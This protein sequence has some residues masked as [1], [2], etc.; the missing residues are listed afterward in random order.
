MV[1]TKAKW[2][3]DQGGCE[4]LK[5]D[6]TANHTRAPIPVAW[7]SSGA[8]SADINAIMHQPSRPQRLLSDLHF[9]KRGIIGWSAGCGALA[10]IDTPSVSRQPY[11]LIRRQ[12][13][14]QP[15]Y[16]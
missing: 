15:V 16:S 5:P 10:L 12:L 6:Q 2:N 8:H 14:G 7:W 11:K 13:A 3:H 4:V 1:L 9:G